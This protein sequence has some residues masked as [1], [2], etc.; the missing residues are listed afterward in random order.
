MVVPVPCHAATLQRRGFDLPALLA[1][2]IA[3]QGRRGRMVWRPS[4]LER[5]SEG[6]RM[7]KLGIEKRRAA[8]QGLYSPREL[9]T[10]TVL[11]VDDVVTSAETVRACASA[12]LRGGAERVYVVALA[13]T[14]ADPRD[15]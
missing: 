10:G 2:A 1:R 12:C 13:R 15:N 5:R 6:V 7:A 8:V 9:L 4:A 3:R 14:C 11:L